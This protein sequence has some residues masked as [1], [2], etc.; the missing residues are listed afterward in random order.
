MWCSSFHCG[1]CVTALS[2]GEDSAYKPGRITNCVIMVLI[3]IAV[4]YKSERKRR[5]NLVA[6]WG[7]RRS[8][9]RAVSRAGVCAGRCGAWWCVCFRVCVFVFMCV[10]VSV[11]VCVCLCACVW[12]FVCARA[13]V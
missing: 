6:T 7:L 5:E 4:A 3:S 8:A 2:L 9:A 1:S 12:E 13:C 11:C 10:C